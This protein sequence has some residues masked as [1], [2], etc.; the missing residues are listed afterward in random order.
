MDFTLWEKRQS[1]P[2]EVVYC[3]LFTII[4]TFQSTCFYHKIN[5]V[6]DYID[7]CFIAF[8]CY[9]CLIIMLCWYR[10]LSNHY[11][12]NNIN[13]FVWL[14][15]FIIHTIL[16]VPVFLDLGIYERIRI[17]PTW[18]RVYGNA[19]SGVIASPLSITFLNDGTRKSFIGCEFFLLVF[20]ILLFNIKLIYAAGK[21]NL[22][23]M[24]ESVCSDWINQIQRQYY[25][26]LHNKHKAGVRLC[27]QQLS[28]GNRI[29][30][31]DAKRIYHML[32]D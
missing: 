21:L 29:T 9:D 16:F 1:T 27:L 18:Y 10:L 28:Y 8:I 13:K 2:I 17:A 15:P 5:P 7:L 32:Y 6:Y 11:V 19:H 24:L 30:I 20:Q 23:Q 31:Y 3:V 4:L 22:L 12:I 26:Y 25:I 14:I